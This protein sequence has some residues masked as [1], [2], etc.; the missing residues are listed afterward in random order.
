MGTTWVSPGLLWDLLWPVIRRAV[1]WNLRHFQT[2]PTRPP[3]MCD[4]ESQRS[5]LAV[6]GDEVWSQGPSPG[7]GLDAHYSK[8]PVHAARVKCGQ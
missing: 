6:S 5:S 4:S 2:L 7:P 3:S 8:Q 1:E